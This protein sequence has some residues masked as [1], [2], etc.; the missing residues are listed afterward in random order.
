[1]I[2]SS[3][4]T[5]VVFIIAAIITAIYYQRNKKGWMGHWL[6]VLFIFVMHFFFFAWGVIIFVFAEW[7]RYKGNSESNPKV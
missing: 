4:P 5:W 7:M 2:V 3:L 1:M 6:A